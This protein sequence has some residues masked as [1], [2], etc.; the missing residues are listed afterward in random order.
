[1][2]LP[3]RKKICFILYNLF[4]L[5]KNRFVRGNALPEIYGLYY[6]FRATVM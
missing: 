2:P 1:M 3:V 4:I 6:I 5:K